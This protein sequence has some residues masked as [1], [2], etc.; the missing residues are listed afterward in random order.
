[1]LLHWGAQY[2]KQLLPPHMQ[3]RVIEPTVDNFYNWTEGAPVVDMNGKT[4][5][6]ILRVP[7][8]DPLVRVSRKKLRKFLSEDLD[9]RVGVN[10]L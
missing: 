4:G 5:E 10:I 1:M 6:V 3:E 8:I 2:L 7:G 9:I